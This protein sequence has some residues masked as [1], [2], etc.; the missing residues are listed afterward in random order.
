MSS[1]E[2]QNREAMLW[3]G[4]E[5][6]QFPSFSLLQPDLQSQ[7]Q[8]RQLN[9]QR[10]VFASI[11]SSCFNQL[12]NGHACELDFMPFELCGA[13]ALLDVVERAAGAGIWLQA[14]SRHPLRGRRQPAMLHIDAR[15]LY[16]LAI[17][18]FGGIPLSPEREQPRR[19]PTDT[20]IR[21]LQR[22][23]QYQ[24]D[25]LSQLLGLDDE[26]WSV[27]ANSVDLLP[28]CG[29]WLRSEATLM[30]GEHAASWHLYWPLVVETPDQPAP[31]LEEA[32]LQAM[33]AIPVQLRI[34]MQQWNMNLAD[35][36]QLRVG[37]VLSLDLAGPLPA[38]LG[39]L[40]WL[41]GHVAEHQ[42]HLVFQ[43]DEILSK[44]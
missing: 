36:S 23:L 44:E 20:E 26:R 28:D 30:V 32:M 22:L 40:S 17:L 18:F 10:R 14:E 7:D 24:L 13:E 5:A 12:F 11:C 25:M 33:P 6:A 2:K 8:L 41:R 15:L 31:A 9:N 21:L 16:R 3:H 4:D 34:R 29:Q 35:V 42:E 38:Y 43:V 27:M 1:R 37:D 39:Q 19:G